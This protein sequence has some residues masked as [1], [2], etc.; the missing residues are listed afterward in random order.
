MA[1]KKT[2]AF[3]VSAALLLTLLSGTASAQ[4]A[5]APKAAQTLPS[6]VVTQVENK[7]II[8]RVE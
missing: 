2:F 3:G 4:E 7:P 1:L 5:V 6:I 8:D